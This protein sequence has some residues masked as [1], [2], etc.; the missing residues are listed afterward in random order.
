M[1]EK[2]QKMT[3][4]PL[5]TQE[6]RKKKKRAKLLTDEVA[7]YI[8]HQTQQYNVR[9]SVLLIKNPCKIF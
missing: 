1:T 4:L 5:V 3:N 9:K 2:E 6:Q 8:V 7:K